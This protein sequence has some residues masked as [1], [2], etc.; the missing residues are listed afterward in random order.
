[1][2]SFYTAFVVNNGMKIRLSVQILRHLPSKKCMDFMHW[3]FWVGEYR[4]ESEEI[5]FYK[6]NGLEKKSLYSLLCLSC[7]KKKDIRREKEV[8]NHEWRS[9]GL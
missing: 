7:C 2:G 1:M 9:I 4:G 8:I 6:V 5:P 3:C